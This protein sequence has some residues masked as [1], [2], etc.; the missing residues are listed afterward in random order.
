MRM[1]RSVLS[2]SLHR[3]KIVVI[4]IALQKRGHLC[5]YVNRYS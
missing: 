3:E 4:E 5:H 2:I 1:L